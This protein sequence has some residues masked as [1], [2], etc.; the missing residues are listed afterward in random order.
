[1]KVQ[2]NNEELICSCECGFVKKVKGIIFSEKGAKVAEVG[3]GVVKYAESDKGFPHT[4]LKCGYGHCDVKELDVFLE[5][6][7]VSRQTQR[8]F[9]A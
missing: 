5:H 8:L 6:P 7:K 1:M 3:E 2:G 9:D 4:C